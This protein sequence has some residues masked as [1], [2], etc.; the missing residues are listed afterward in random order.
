MPCYFRRSARRWLTPLLLAGCCLVTAAVAAE[1]QLPGFETRDI[2]G[3]LLS[4]EAYRGQWVVV[5]FWA[6]WC[7][8]CRKEI[9]ELDALHR[10]REDVTVI[11]LAFEDVEPQAIIDF[12][13]TYPAAYPIALVD[14]YEPPEAFGAPRVLPTTIV[15]DPRGHQRKTFLGPVTREMIESYIDPPAIEVVDDA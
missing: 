13:V 10:E 9:P 3:E 4:L 8:P 5:N 14:L 6:T 11:G 15:I 1:D 2:H 12:L 7:K